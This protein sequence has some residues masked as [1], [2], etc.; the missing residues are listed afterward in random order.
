MF[1]GPFF[2]SVLICPPMYR[3]PRA[4]DPLL[5]LPGAA[6]EAMVRA[7]SRFYSAGILSR[8]RLPRPAV[9]IGNITLG[10][11]GKTPLVI[12]AAQVLIKLGFI[13]AVL[14]RG[15]G[16]RNSDKLLIVSPT[17]ELP[18]PES[19]LGDEPAL[20]RRRVPSAWLGVSKDRRAAAEE[21]AGRAQGIV[22]V[23][24]D[25]FQHQKVYRDLDIAIV[26]RTQHLMANH[27]FPRGTL[28]EPV[29]HLRRCHAV[30]IN[31]IQGPG[32][33]DLTE[34]AIRSLHVNAPL[35]HCDQKIKLLVPFSQWSKGEEDWRGPYPRSALVVAAIGNPERF[36]RDVVRLGI[37][38]CGSR[39]F[40]DHHRINS[41][42]WLA[43]REQADAGAADAIITTEKDAMK[44]EQPP[45]FPLLVSVQATEMSEADRFELLLKNSIEERL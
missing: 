5:F 19:I 28:R 45:D 26:D 25:G 30:V 31:G 12:Y 11:S 29:S 16:R 44:I 17:R 13:P 18:S 14:T 38:V 8:H 20:V 7:R 24:D 15:Y 43:C 21:I 32:E 36:R 9:S 3:I 40:A 33:Q 27:I 39:F 4:L 1:R 41:K 10:G 23:L 35:F 34:S 42:E 2:L 6:F 22:F 37:E